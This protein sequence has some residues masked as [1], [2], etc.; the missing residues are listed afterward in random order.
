MQGGLLQMAAEQLKANWRLARG[1]AKWR[2]WY[3][4]LLKAGRE[5]WLGWDGSIVGTRLC[6]A[7]S[8]KITHRFSEHVFLS[9]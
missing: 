8:F 9:R 1:A 2:T 7:D 3:G 6:E 4:A 5:V